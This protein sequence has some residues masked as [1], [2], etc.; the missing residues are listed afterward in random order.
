MKRAPDEEEEDEPKKKKQ[1]KHSEKSKEKIPSSAVGSPV[2][3]RTLTSS[4]DPRDLASSTASSK[5]KRALKSGAGSG[6]QKLDLGD[7]KDQ[8]GEESSSEEIFI[9][10]SYQKK[11]Q[12][13]KK[14][15][16]EGDRRQ[17]NTEGDYSRCVHRLL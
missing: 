17:Y 8:H 5:S 6:L 11:A 2:S 12:L 10:P 3:P 16:T 15:D 4:N 7:S 9:D 1:K 14:A 13:G